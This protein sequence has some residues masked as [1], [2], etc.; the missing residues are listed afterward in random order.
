MEVYDDY[1]VI[2]RY[3]YAKGDNNEREYVLQIFVNNPK[4]SFTPDLAKSLGIKNLARPVCELRNRGWAIE[5]IKGKPGYVFLGMA[6]V[7]GCEERYNKKLPR[8]RHCKGL[9]YC[10]DCGAQ[11]LPAPVTPQPEV[12]P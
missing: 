7:K 1:E 9:L 11:A 4:K 5:S 8:C 6:S 10:D 3:E 12:L 2:D